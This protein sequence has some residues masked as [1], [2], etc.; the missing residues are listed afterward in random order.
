MTINRDLANL[1]PTLYQTSSKIL[2]GVTTAR[3]DF[4]NQGTV[5]PKFQVET[6][7]SDNLNR[8]ASVTTNNS[9]T[10]GATLLLA[11][12]RGTTT[13]AVTI[14]Q[15]D[16]QI[17]AISFQG[18]DGVN[19]V[20]AAR[21]EAK[22]D[23]TPGSDD[24]PGR[25][26]FFTT[27]DGAASSTERMRIP[28]TGGLQVVNCVSVGNATPSTSGA[29]ITFPATQ[30]ASTDANTLDDYEEGTFTPTLTGETTAGTTTYTTQTGVYT[31]IGRQVTCIVSI[32]YTAA[33]GT[34]NMLLGGLPFTIASPGA[35][36][37]LET[38]GLN[39]TGGTYL[40]VFGEPSSTYCYVFGEADD[41]NRTFQ[42]VTN[43]TAVLRFTLTYF[44]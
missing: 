25:L 28:A 23:G 14:V 35:V 15:N 22:V 36:A 10:G 17:G 27:A 5:N 24:M 40:V 33:T 29:G 8:F 9:D 2:V 39:W 20:E 44:V 6:A 41:A 3:S 18:A 32:V 12:T 16:D 11:K 31:K 38:S 37:A 34:G 1:V 30:S 19:L 26:V 4:F 13:G 43:E 42:T 7:A 21:I